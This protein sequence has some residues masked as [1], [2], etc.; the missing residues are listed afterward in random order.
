[1]NKLIT[2]Y[3]GNCYITS[4]YSQS[5]AE[6]EK[7]VDELVDQVS[8]YADIIAV[9]KAEFNGSDFVKQVIYK[10]KE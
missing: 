7:M 6:C 3:S 4:T 1:M 5:I 10:G 2:K 8:V 9:S